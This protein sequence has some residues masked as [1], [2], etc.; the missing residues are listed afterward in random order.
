MASPRP[1]AVRT[2]GSNAFAHH[3]MAVRVPAII[4]ETLDRNPDYP[5]SIQKALA[6]LKHAIEKDAPL[7]LFDPP[8]PDYDLWADRFAPHQGETWLDTEWI[9]CEALAYRLMLTATRYWDTGRDP[10]RPFKEEEMASAALWE[11]LGAALAVEGKVEERLAARLA[12]TLWGNRIDLSIKQAAE[13]GVHAHKDHLLTDHLPK[14]VAHLI[15]HPPGDV[16]VIMD[17]AGT[18][19]ALDYALVDLLLEDD[20]AETVTLH[21]KLTP[22]LVGNANVPDVHRLLGLMHARGGAAAA[23]ASRLYRHLDTGRLRVVPDFFWSTAGRLWE[24]PPRLRAALEGARLVLLK[25]DFNYR[26][27]TNDAIWPPDVSL[28]DAF[29][30]FPAPLLALRTPKCDTL[31]GVSREIIERLDAEAKPGWRTS[32]TYGVAQF[33]TF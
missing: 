5:A 1:A 27:A 24:L 8:T 12:M 28:S 17:N 33:A 31:V 15:R 11:A 9:F 14:A 3:S 13:Q 25:G 29:R 7:H 22:V 16:H 6:A 26:R 18:E 23:L 10:F 20:L 21:V 2:D 30:D 4:Q 19:Q 32:G